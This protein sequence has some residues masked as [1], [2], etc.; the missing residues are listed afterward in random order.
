VQ[1]L[2]ALD[3]PPCG[4]EGLEPHPW[5]D[6]ALDK[7]MVLLN[8]IISELSFAYSNRALELKAHQQFCE[9]F[10]EQRLK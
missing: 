4:V 2:L 6:Q 7:A 10:G 5:L 3:G 1:R 8:H 9:L